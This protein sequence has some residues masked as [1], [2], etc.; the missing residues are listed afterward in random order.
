MNRKLI[1]LIFTLFIAILLPSCQ[2][3]ADRGK[4]PADLIENPLSA[5]E[6]ADEQKLPVLTFERQTHDFGRIIQ[7]E[8][9][10][11]SF[12]FTNTG[13]A[14]LLISRVNSSC[15]CT[16]PE[17]TSKPLSPGETGVISVAFDSRGRRGTQTQTVK[18]VANTQPNIIP[19]TIR[20]EVITPET[21]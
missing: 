21:M 4:L 18:V 20:A 8:K 16:V 10:S 6:Q 5:E 11:F 1:F 15:G 13:Q 9:V 19:L 17:Y 14:P 7:G 3:R 12:R 2:Q